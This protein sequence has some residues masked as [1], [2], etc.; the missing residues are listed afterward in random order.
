MSLIE[1]RRDAFRSWLRT[2]ELTVAEVARLAGV[3]PSTLYSYLD[4]KS[5][6]MKGTTQEAI[7]RAF[8]VPVETLFTSASLTN[9]QIG[10]WGKVG[11]RAEVYPLSDYSAD[12]MYEVAVPPGLDDEQEYLAF[13]IEGF[14]MPPAEPGWLVFFRKVE[15]TPEDLINSACLIDTADGLRLFKKLR[16]G[17]LPG[18]YNLESWDGSPLMENVQVVT[19]LPFAAITPGR[20]AR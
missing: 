19:A 6:S 2:N 11:A 17:Y 1:S 7:A 12:P 9:R 15:T 5:A 16:R 8:A 18:R 4:G 14:S 3:P 10:V 20:K 13:E